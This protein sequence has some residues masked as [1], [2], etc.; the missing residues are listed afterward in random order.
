MA[1]GKN[2]LLQQ[3]TPA[4]AQGQGVNCNDNLGKESVPILA[5]AEGS[6]NAPGARPY[7]AIYKAI[8][9]KFTTLVV[10]SAMDYRPARVS[11]CIWLLCASREAN[12]SGTIGRVGKLCRRDLLANGQSSSNHQLNT[13][14]SMSSL[15]FARDIR[16][17]FRS[18][19][20]E[21]MSF[22]F[23]LASYADVTQNAESIYARIA[24]GSMPC[25][26]PWSADKL[27]Q[28]KQ[29]IDEGMPA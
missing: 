4:Q 16:P 29:W 2:K 10:D 21:A 15:S 7:R 20:V 24:D 19:D 28:L 27:A 25:D 1:R 6:V 12:G 26:E 3:G 8:S 23:D 5:E 18:E 14:G 9:S 22:V 13:E 17:L 11:G